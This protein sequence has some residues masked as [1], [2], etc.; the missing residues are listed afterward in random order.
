MV[1]CAAHAGVAEQLMVGGGEREGA[2]WVI[3]SLSFD[4]L[5]CIFHCPQ[6][7]P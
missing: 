7:I 4:Y 2:H 1:G 5:H 6:G 3:A